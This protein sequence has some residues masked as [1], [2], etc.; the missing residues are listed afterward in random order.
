MS[1]A[2]DESFFPSYPAN[3]ENNPATN[4]ADNT[5]DGK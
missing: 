2:L 5:P 4:K 1:Q 3:N